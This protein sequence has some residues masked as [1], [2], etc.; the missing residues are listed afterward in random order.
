MTAPTP[1]PRPPPGTRRRLLLLLAL[2]AAGWLVGAIGSALTSN[3]SWYGAIP[4]AIAL[5][6]LFV[7][8]PSRCEPTDRRRDMPQNGGAGA[9][10]PTTAK[11]DP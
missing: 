6:W 10:P 5:G 11:G 9:S 7:A 8:D 3:A 2:A 1:G 4:A